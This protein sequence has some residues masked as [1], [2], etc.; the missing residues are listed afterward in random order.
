MQ[1]SSIISQSDTEYIPRDD[2]SE[3]K[4]VQD[5]SGV[6]ELAYLET[7]EIKEYHMAD[8]NFGLPDEMIPDD[9]SR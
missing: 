5:I 1:T 3:A 8:Y 6:G 9:L 2:E 7:D 4:R